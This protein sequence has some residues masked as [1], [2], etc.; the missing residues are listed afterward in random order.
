MS[1]TEFIAKSF[2]DCNNKFKVRHFF[3]ELSSPQFKAGLLQKAKLQSM[4]CKKLKNKVAKRYTVAI[5]KCS[6]K[7]TGILP[8]TCNQRA[9]AIQF[10]V[11]R[12]EEGMQLVCTW[13]TVKGE[14]MKKRVVLR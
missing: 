6:L 11:C 14:V 5:I 8:I 9:R 1:K 13:H 10:T 3:R 12:K 7:L 2:Y 4:I